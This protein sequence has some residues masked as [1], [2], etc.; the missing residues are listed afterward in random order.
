MPLRV[1]RSRCH[2]RQLNTREL[3]LKTANLIAPSY[4]DEGFGSLSEQSSERVRKGPKRARA[5]VED[6]AI[7]LFNAGLAK[8]GAQKEAAVDLG[9]SVTHLS[10]FTAGRS[11]IALHR[12]LTMGD[13]RKE[14][15]F[16]IVENLSGRWGMAPPQLED[17]VQLSAAE[18]RL[19]AWLMRTPVWP[20][21]LGTLV[22][23]EFYRV[24][25]E[26]L[27]VAIK[28]ATRGE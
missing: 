14:A 8:M 2:L 28:N 6:E 20:L 15:A 16:T 23:R 24:D 1:R 4:A 26:L 22:A 25:V 19:L 13:K 21:F 12:L 27:E 18:A 17:T 7:E 10:D 3:I 11:T 9:L 5:V